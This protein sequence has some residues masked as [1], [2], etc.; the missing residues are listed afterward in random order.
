MPLPAGTIITFKSLL[1][2]LQY[3]KANKHEF[4]RMY[5]GVV[6]VRKS[7]SLPDEKEGGQEEE[8]E[9]SIYE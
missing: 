7:D 8:K 9:A 1:E 4:V 3:M 6:V 5:G 2:M